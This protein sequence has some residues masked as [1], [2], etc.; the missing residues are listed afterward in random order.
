MLEGIVIVSIIASTAL[1]SFSMCKAS[2]KCKSIDE[3]VSNE[4]MDFHNDFSEQ[5]IQL[6]HMKQA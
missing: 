5:E 6:L 4:A 2:S 1:F 3:L